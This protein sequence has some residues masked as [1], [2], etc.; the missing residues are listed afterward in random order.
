MSGEVKLR[1][2]PFCGG[3]DVVCEGFNIFSVRC[4]SCGASTA[5]RERAVYAEGNWNIRA[6]PTRDA[7]GMG[8]EALIDAFQ[9][10]VLRKARIGTRGPDPVALRVQSEYDAARQALS[11]RL[12]TQPDRPEG[13]EPAAWRYK[14]AWG[15]WAYCQAVDNAKGPTV[16]TEKQPLYTRPSTAAAERPL[17]SSPVADNEGRSAVTKAETERDGLRDRDEALE[18]FLRVVNGGGNQGLPAGDNYSALDVF[19]DDRGDADDTYNLSESLGY[20]RTQHSGW[21]DGC[22]T[23]FITEAGRQALAALNQQGRV[24]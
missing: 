6:A 10:A 19:C 20:T 23:V 11:A 9:D 15:R 16:V 22:A 1:E 5:P 14:D 18:W 12:R 4:K 2:C 8:G 17:S 24:G 3:A 13:E 21:G 7:S